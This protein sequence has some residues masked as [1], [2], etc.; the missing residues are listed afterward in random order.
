MKWFS[1]KDA[2][3]EILSVNK[4]HLDSAL[5]L[6]Y[7]WYQLGNYK[8]I[9]EILQDID[10]LCEENR[11]ILRL[12]RVIST[13]AY[14]L[15]LCGSSTEA[16]EALKSLGKNKDIYSQVL[17]LCINYEGLIRKGVEP[18]ILKEFLRPNR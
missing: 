16:K 5:R 2:Y 11:K 15:H 1:A 6:A 18:N 9:V 13:K 7:V 14:L 8:K 10:K 17:E 4:Y 12:D 3:E